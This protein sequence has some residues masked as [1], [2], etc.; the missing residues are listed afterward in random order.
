MMAVRTGVAV[1]VVAFLVQG[2]P[3]FAQTAPLSNNDPARAL[4]QGK[5][6]EPAFDLG[7]PL[8]ADQAAGAQGLR[9]VLTR[10]D[11]LGEK[12][13]AGVDLNTTWAPYRGK[14]VRLPDLRAIAARAEAAYAKAGYPFVAVV[15]PAQS[16]EGGVVKLRVVEGRITD[17][18]VITASPAARRQAT[19]AMAPL[20][21]RQPLTLADVEAAYESAR[22]VP[23]LALSGALRRGSQPGG[24]DLV[25]D[26]RRSAWRSYA[27]VNNFYAP[28]LGR[29]AIL[30]GLDYNGESRFGD[31]TSLQLF[32]T[33]GGEQKTVRLSHV[34]R[35]NASGTSVGAAVL[36]S[37]ADPQGV[38][39]PLDLATEAVNARFE[40]AQPILRRST[41]SLTLTAALELSDQE[42]RVFRTVSLTQDTLRIASLAARAS[43]RRPL[44]ELTA[45]AELRQGLDFGGSSSKGDAGLS[46][47]DADPQATVVRFSAEG[48]SRFFG[49]ISLVARL[50]GQYADRSLVASEEF[51][52]GELTLGRGY[53]PGSA[54]GDQA[55]G[56]SLELRSS[57]WRIPYG[58]RAQPFAFYDVARLWNVDPYGV[59]DRTLSSFGGGVRFDLPS[60]A[61]LD[62][63]YAAPQTAALGLGDKRPAST[64]LVNLTMSLDP[65]I[66]AARS[67]FK[68]T[69]K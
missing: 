34:R 49:P 67:L 68:G 42:T 11:F 64:I 6:G 20:V 30:G 12:A 54:L 18:S 9:F 25:I 47:P 22:E 69:A 41:R 40:V 26:A 15:V 3:A 13:R 62:V 27:N 31:Q 63:T 17:L 58:F 66:G 14:T 48:H 46:R 50:E 4:P 37:T 56:G 53:E 52:W 10:V 55:I 29:W 32:S 38:F 51:A 45:V 39:T 19:A 16:V 21:N 28:A 1:G 59:A 2:G 35:L 7:K 57:G 24:M 8:S 36:Y 61:R 60:K 65:A 33:E 23:G 5:P 44:G 43:L